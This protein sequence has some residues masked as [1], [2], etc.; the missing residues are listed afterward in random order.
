MNTLNQ[1]F[2]QMK[3]DIDR[4]KPS[5]GLCVLFTIQPDAFDRLYEFQELIKS[6]P[7]FT[8]GSAYPIP[9]PGNMNAGYAFNKHKGHDAM[10]NSEYGMLRRELLDYM[11]QATEEYG[12]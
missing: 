9:G 3:I 10:Y 12:S 2:K 1:I 11:I 8:G 4:L 7:K 6:W 5:Y